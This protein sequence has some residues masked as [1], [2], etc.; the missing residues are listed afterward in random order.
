LTANSQKD[1]KEIRLKVIPGASRNEIV[2]LSDGVL[3]VR[4][5]APPVRGK[6][7]KELTAFLSRTLGVSK[8]ALTIVKGH[9]SRNKVIT[10]EGMTRDDIIGRLTA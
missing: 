1:N 5:A 6:A 10:V 3:H 4:I 8:S 2:G 7:N 9:T